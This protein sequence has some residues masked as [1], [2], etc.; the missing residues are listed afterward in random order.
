MPAPPR[1]ETRS[2]TAGDG[3]LLVS[4]VTAEICTYD[5]G[6]QAFVRFLEFVDGKLV[7]IETGS[8]G[9]AR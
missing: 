8:Y 5:F 3:A 4:S 2:W 6:P 9:Y 1:V 7:K